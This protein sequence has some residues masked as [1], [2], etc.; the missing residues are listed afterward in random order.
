LSKTSSRLLP[1]PRIGH[2]PLYRGG[3]RRPCAGPISEGL[4]ELEWLP[5]A[6]WESVQE[7]P[8]SEQWH[9]LHFIGHGD[10]G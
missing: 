5:Q 6:S 4:I 10:S 2:T 9:V 1:P 8:L 7:K 3:G